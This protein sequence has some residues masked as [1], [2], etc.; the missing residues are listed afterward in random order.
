MD[1]WRFRIREATE[2]LRAAGIGEATREAVWL[3]EEATGVPWARWVTHGS[4]GPAAE[5]KARYAAWI[6]RRCRREPFAYIVGHREFM[7]IDLQVT[8]SVLIPRPET[9]LLVEA[10]LAR[11]GQEPGP[12]DVVDVGTGSGAIALALARLGRPDWRIRGID[13][14]PDALR[15][16]AAN[17]R[18]LGLTVTW[19]LGDLLGPLDYP[20]D[21]VVAN[22]PYV[23]AA[24]QARLAP[25]LAYE[26]EL[27]LFA[28]DGGFREI[29][30]LI[31]ALPGSV[32]R[33]GWVFLE[34]GYGQADRVEHALRVAGTAWVERIQDYN[35]I[36][37]VMVARYVPTRNGT[38]IRGEEGCRNGQVDNAGRTGPATGVGPG[39]VN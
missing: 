9:E 25:E 32:N 11:L 17:G 19:A 38:E 13:L 30:R 39:N 36:D 8:P 35:G 6:E 16:A 1:E 14:S 20:V 2:Q 22:L 5:A 33:P 29:E 3:W 10:V 4:S 21:A 31:A 15:V 12:V 28:E 18:R 34:I 26:P 27:A 24:D 37:R 23:D 7:G